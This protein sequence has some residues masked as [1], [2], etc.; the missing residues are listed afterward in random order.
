MKLSTL[1]IRDFVEIKPP[2]ESLAERLTMAGLEVKKVAPS[3]DGKDVVFEIEIT[4]NRPDW[5]SHLGVAREIAA[6]DNL[7]LRV[8]EAEKSAGRPAAPGWKLNLRELEGCPY[9]TAVYLEGLTQGPTP[10]LIR[11]RLEACGLRSINLIVDITNY[12]LLEVGQ[13]LHAFDAD[14]LK[15]KEIQIRRAKADEPFTAIDGVARKLTP[16]DLVIAD[17]QETIA[18]AGVM[19]GKDTE[20]SARTRNIL[21]ESA[22]FHPRWVRQTSLKHRL[23]SDSSYRFERRVDPE[24]VDFA[25]ERAVALIKKYAQPRF[26]SAEIKAGGPPARDRARIHLSAAEIQKKLGVEIKPAQTAQLL[27]R[28]GLEVKPESRDGFSVGVPSFRGDLTTSIDLVE[29]AARMTGYDRI[30]ETLPESRPLEAGELAIGRVEEK[31]RAFFSGLGAYETVT[32]SLISAAGLDPASDLAGAVS[33]TNPQHQD[34]RWLRPTLATSLLEVVGRNI[35]WG[36]PGASFFELANVYAKAPG[37]PHPKEAMTLGFAAYGRWRPAN[38]QEPVRPVSFYDVKGAV[39]AFFERLGVAG[40]E[41]TR[42]ARSYLD[43]GVS[44]R[45]FLGNETLGW[46][47]KVRPGVGRIWDI[48]DEVYYAELSLDKI[49]RQVQWQR[50][51]AELPRY[52]TVERDL[53]VTVREEV[54]S[55]QIEKEI[56]LHGQGL[57]RKIELFDL[58]RGGR[59]GA[60]HKNLSYRIVYQSLERTLLSEEILALHSA[61]AQKVVDSFAAKFQG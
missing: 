48:E 5:L 42:G 38:W 49:C 52:P 10:E 6:V 53:S 7:S 23:A 46:L 3:A 16:R 31:A 50:P 56:L 55:A 45:I 27:A 17:A 22:Y 21:L 13:P 8:P 47:G 57:V 15:G 14:L 34:L 9:Y 18:L 35:R 28:L 40:A 11:E 43:A 61:I 44:Q 39:E 4:T 51:L 12:V 30:P 2:L 24:G 37:G 58:F 54:R 33:I 60:G 25:R 26:V 1:W 29:E 19:G 20:I 32:F 41:F 36:S 59:V